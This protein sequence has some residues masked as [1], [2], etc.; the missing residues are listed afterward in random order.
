M[1]SESKPRLTLE[2]GAA[3]RCDAML[4]KAADRSMLG[5]EGDRSRRSAKEQCAAH[6]GVSA[7]HIAPI[8]PESEEDVDGVVDP[9]SEQQRKRYEIDE[10]PFPIQQGHQGQETSDAEGEGGEG[11]DKFAP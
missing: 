10:V 11:Q 9:G 6:D 3:F 2:L 5:V 1:R 8:A 7:P 4:T